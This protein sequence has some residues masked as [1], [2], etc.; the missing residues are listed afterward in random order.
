MQNNPIPLA[1]FIDAENANC[2]QIALILS[3]AE[4]FWRQFF[5]AHEAFIERISIHGDAYL[6][7]KLNK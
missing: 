3:E 1:L 5:Q 4:K 6:V 7:I 2:H